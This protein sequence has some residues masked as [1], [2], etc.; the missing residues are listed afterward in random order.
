[1]RYVLYVLVCSVLYN[2]PYEYG[3]TR[4]RTVLDRV[5]SNISRFQFINNRELS[6][7][8][9]QVTGVRTQISCLATFT[10]RA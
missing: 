4:T 5:I 9:V 6:N 10:F 2:G 8:A 7:S 1:M 3:Y